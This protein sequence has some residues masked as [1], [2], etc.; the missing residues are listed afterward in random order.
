MIYDTYFPCPAKHSVSKICEF[1]ICTSVGVPVIEERPFIN[2]SRTAR[3]QNNLR[4][5]LFV[6]LIMMR[7]TRG[8]HCQA[9]LNKYALSTSI[10]VLV[11]NVVYDAKQS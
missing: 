9:D 10:I 5:G 1:G 2:V 3:L 4:E 11:K 8:V 7:F 6:H